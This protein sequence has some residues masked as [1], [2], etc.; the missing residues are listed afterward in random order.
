MDLRA[1]KPLYIRA[2]GR[3]AGSANPS[4]PSN[5]DPDLKRQWAKKHL[6]ALE[7]E[8]QRFCNANPYEVR[9]SEDF[10]AGVIRIETVHPPF[11]K[12]LEALLAFG[13][14]VSCLR[15]S[16]D[17]L[18]WQLAS[19]GGK[20]PGTGIFFPV[21][22]QNTIDTQVRIAK[23]TFGISDDAI[24]IIKSFQPYHAGDAYKSTHL[25]R[26]NTLW[27]IDKHRHVSAVSTS[28]T[29]QYC[30]RNGYREGATLPLKVFNNCTVMTLPLSYKSEVEFNP[31]MTAELRFFD[32]FEGIEV[33]YS[34][35]VEI[36]DFVTNNILPA[37]AG[38]FSQTEVTRKS[39]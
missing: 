6:E 28:T 16:L 35:L 12:A 19:I 10:D 25:W 22:E 14:F 29:W 8:I 27:N 30:L 39:L 18:A 9:A 24:A 2:L 38:F 32:D 3:T 23:A 20:R 5:F 37:F 34:D 11:D 4:L 17:H 15:A 1:E 36:Y 21:T 33:G 7:A 13:D 26:L 31:A